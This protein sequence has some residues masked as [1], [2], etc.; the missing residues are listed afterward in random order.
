VV[1]HPPARVA[2]PVLERLQ[3]VGAGHRHAAG[4]P[5]GLRH[6]AELA[7]GGG[8]FRVEAREVEHQREHEEVGREEE[9][10]RHPGVARRPQRVGAE[11]VGDERDEVARRG[12]EVR[13][14]RGE[15]RD[16]PLRL[17]GEQRL[18]GGAR[19]EVA[20]RDCRQ[21]RGAHGRRQRRQE[22][23]LRGGVG[24]G[25]GEDRGG[26]AVRLVQPARQLRQR[27]HVAHPRRREQRD[28]GRR[29]G[30]RGFGLAVAHRR[31]AR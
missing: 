5:D 24:A 19:G 3:D 28:V 16:G 12:P 31:R 22:R 30:R 7:N 27:R 10:A 8:E 4:E 6:V 29:R 2:G 25:V 20:Q 26:E 15:R 18:D 9:V 13:Q 11:E 1:H 21:R 14:H 23:A 17:D